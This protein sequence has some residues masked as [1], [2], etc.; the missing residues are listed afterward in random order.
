MKEVPKQRTTNSFTSPE[1]EEMIKTGTLATRARSNKVCGRCHSY[2]VGNYTTVTFDSGDKTIRVSPRVSKVI[3]DT[4]VAL[5]YK[6]FPKEYNK[7][8]KYM[9]EDNS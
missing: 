3:K 6:C 1:V 2:I 5:C 7:Y 9:Y 4:K 8:S